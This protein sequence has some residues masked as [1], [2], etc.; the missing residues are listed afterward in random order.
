VVRRPQ[1]ASRWLQGGPWR[2]ILIGT[3]LG[4]ALVVTFLP[5]ILAAGQNMFRDSQRFNVA[6]AVSLTQHGDGPALTAA[7]FKALGVIGKG[8]D[9]QAFWTDCA[10]PED[11]DLC[12]QQIRQG[13]NRVFLT[14]YTR[15]W[16]GNITSVAIGQVGWIAQRSGEIGN[17]QTQ[18]ELCT[19]VYGA[20]FNDL[21]TKRLPDVKYCR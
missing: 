7:G 20:T 13:R 4:L 3:T 14:W 15:N 9:R 2:Q 11:D 8:D 10:N 17:M 18:L 6:D 1:P 16:R 12:L 21:L 19:T 5:A